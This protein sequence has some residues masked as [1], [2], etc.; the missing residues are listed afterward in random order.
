MKVFIVEMLP[1]T[2]THGMIMDPGGTLE[3]FYKRKKAEKYVNK[4]VLANV[5]IR[6]KKVK[7][8]K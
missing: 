3:V 5:R 6:K 2:N 7:G 4:V 8:K 1:V